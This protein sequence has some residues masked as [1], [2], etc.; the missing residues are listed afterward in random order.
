MRYSQVASR[1]HS[2]HQHPPCSQAIRTGP[3]T[4]IQSITLRTLQSLGFQAELKAETFKWVALKSVSISQNSH[5]MFTRNLL[6]NKIWMYLACPNCRPRQIFQLSGCKL[7]PPQTRNPK[8]T[9]KL[10]A[11]TE[12]NRSL[13]ARQPH[14]KWLWSRQTECLNNRPRSSNRTKCS[15]PKSNR[16]CWWRKFSKASSRCR[17]SSLRPQVSSSTWRSKRCF[18]KC[19]NNNSSSRYSLQARASTAATYSKLVR[20]NPASRKWHR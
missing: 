4:P 10:Q 11:L 20:L 8:T 7:P 6:H 3:G 19:S 1:Q 9:Y 15:W 14:H 16:F 2:L 12:D 18:S 13:D 5:L 17:Y